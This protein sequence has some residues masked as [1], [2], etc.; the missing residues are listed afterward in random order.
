MISIDQ[1]FLYVIAFNLVSQA[2]VALKPATKNIVFETI[3]SEE[4]KKKQMMDKMFKVALND[5]ATDWESKVEGVD[6]SEW[7]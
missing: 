6:E 4:A 2:A 1:S 7:D 3:L 5:N